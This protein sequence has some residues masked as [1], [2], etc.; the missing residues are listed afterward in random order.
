[1]PVVDGKEYPYT[2]AGIAA[3]KKA[4]DKA[5][6]YKSPLER[7]Y[8]DSIDHDKIKAKE[9]AERLDDLKPRTLLEKLA[10][11][12]AKKKK[13]KAREEYLASPEAAER[14]KAGFRPKTGDEYFKQRQDAWDQYLSIFP[15]P[16]DIPSRKRTEGMA[17][18]LRKKPKSAY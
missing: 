1:M 11:Y 15:T 17:K 3:A 4:R 18:T 16:R 12:K 10:H 13:K 2:K 6:N 9:E 14:K 8:W 5:I 7:E